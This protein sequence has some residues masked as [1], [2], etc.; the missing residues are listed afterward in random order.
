[1]TTFL[2]GAE[3]MA[4]AI[5]G[6]FFL[7]FWRETG[8]RLFAIFAISF[9]LLAANWAGLGIYGANTEAVRYPYFLRLAA[10]CLI[11]YGIAH[12]NRRGS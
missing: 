12:K 10:F 5:A 4:A 7:R 8:D 9:W 6:L 11:L 3:T 1:M 2:L